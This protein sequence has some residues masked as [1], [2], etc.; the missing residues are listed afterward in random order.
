[1]RPFLYTHERKKTINEI[2]FCLL[3]KN[4]A[5]HPIARS[6]RATPRWRNT[7]DG[8]R[9]ICG[10][11][12]DPETG[13]AR[14]V[15]TL[16]RRTGHGRPVLARL[17]T[18][19]DLDVLLRL[20]AMTAIHQV[21]ERHRRASKAGKK[22]LQK[23]VI[24]RDARRD[25]ASEKDVGSEA[26]Q[27]AAWAEEVEGEVTLTFGSMRS[28]L[29]E[30]GY[31]PNTQ[32]NFTKLRKTLWLWENLGVRYRQWEGH[33]KKTNK[34][35]HSF[36]SAVEYPER[37]RGPVTIRLSKEYMR[38]IAR[39]AK[40]Y[41][42]LPLPLPLS[43]EASL[44]LA[45]FLPAFAR[46]R[47]APTTCPIYDLRYICDTIGIPGSQ[48]REPWYL[49]SRLSEYLETVNT[50]FAATH[51]RRHYKMKMLGKNKVQFLAAMK[52]KKLVE[53]ERPD[54]E[55]D[56][57]RELQKEMVA[58]ESYIEQERERGASDTALRHEL[59]ELR[60]LARQYDY[61]VE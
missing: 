12:P 4:F 34:G 45:L 21:Q 39:D 36:V 2:S 35:F 42:R 30:L 7:K 49:Q 24:S 32:S 25:G 47:R 37:G 58:L 11:H 44:N 15:L 13:K 1:M 40:Y 61:A 48:D 10:L 22:A 33:G 14:V 17:P 26:Y 41:V 51:P 29:V 6:R 31:N 20:S 8:E 55:T 46:E 59:E 19:F 27:Q 54:I 5:H 18:S 38:T 43:S 3:N 60:D 16:P 28:L 57:V 56:E 9:L 23:A 50:Y 53:Q 52:S